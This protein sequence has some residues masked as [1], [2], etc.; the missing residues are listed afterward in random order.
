MSADEVDGAPLTLSL[1]QQE[2][3]ALRLPEPQHVALMDLMR[4]V[5]QHVPGEVHAAD[6]GRGVSFHW[7]PY[8]WNTHR[9]LRVMTDGSVRWNVKQLHRLVDSG[10]A[11]RD[12][13]QRFDTVI[14]DFAGDIVDS[15]RQMP[16]DR[17][18]DQHARQRLFDGV[19]EFMDHLD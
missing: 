7:R 19:R 4:F 16:C 6:L 10:R 13:M 5:I 1:V 15:E 17:I 18:T 12:S 14:S 9:L 11:T 3:G 8:G 2:L